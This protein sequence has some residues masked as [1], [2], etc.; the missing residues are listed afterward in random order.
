MPHVKY[1]AAAAERYELVATLLADR[2]PV[3]ASVIELGAAPGEQSIALAKAGY[4]VTAVDIG[5]FSDEWEEAPEGTMV[6]RFGEA[7]VDLILWNLEQTPYPLPD[8]SFDAVVM[9]EVFEHMR[10]YPVRS[11]EEAHRILK[12]GGYL[13]FTTP[14]AAYVRNRLQLLMGKNTASS[15]PDWIGGVPFA[16]HAREYTFSEAEELMRYAG[17]EIDLVTGRHLHINSGRDSKIAALGKRLVDRA[18]QV[19]PSIG[20]AIVMVARRPV[21]Q[22]F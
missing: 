15:L 5:E 13:F 14:N 8:G 18:A 12:P 16:R 7:G 6:Q 9:T 4:Q 20:P 17:F 3:G 2:A 1:S 21:A 11:L 10:D 19:R 22:P